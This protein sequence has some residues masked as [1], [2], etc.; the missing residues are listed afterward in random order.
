MAGMA[1]LF[2]DMWVQHNRMPEVIVSDRD[3]KFMSKF[4]TLLMKKVSTKLKFSTTFH[5][6]IDGQTERV[7]EILNQYICNYIASDHKD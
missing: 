2:F 6:Q 5:L 3:V 7:N 1:K 4:W